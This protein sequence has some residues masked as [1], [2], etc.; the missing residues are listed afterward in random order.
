MRHRIPATGILQR[1]D[2]FDV[3]I[4][5]RE[6]GDVGAFDKILPAPENVVPFPVSQKGG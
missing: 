5:R 4:D 2:F 1:N 6:T 3:L